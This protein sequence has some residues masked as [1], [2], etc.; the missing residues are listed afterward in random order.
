MI[1][2]RIA[3][4]SVN[5]AP[6]PDYPTGGESVCGHLWVRFTQTSD[7]IPLTQSAWEPTPKE[8]ELLNRGAS[9]ILEIVGF[10]MPAVA[11]YVEDES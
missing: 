10:G 2:R 1:T 6:P 9:V 3:N 5:L 4:A 7:G 11:L 8:L